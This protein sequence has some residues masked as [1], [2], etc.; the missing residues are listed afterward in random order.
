MAF[1][2]LAHFGQPKTEVL[3]P[4]GAPLGIETRKEIQNCSSFLRNETM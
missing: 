1:M 3:S 2:Q 4:T